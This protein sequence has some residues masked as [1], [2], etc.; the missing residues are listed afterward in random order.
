VPSFRP[1]LSTKALFVTLVSSVA[2]ICLSTGAQAAQ[3]KKKHA[4]AAAPAPAP[5]PKGPPRLIVAIS[6]DQ[7]SADLF[8]QYRKLYTGGLA[9]LQGGAVFASGF[10]SHAA[11]ETCPGHSTILTGVHPGRNGII[12]NNWYDL[13]LKRADKRVYCAE[14]EKDKDSTSVAPVVSAVHLK[15]PTLGELMKL[16][17]PESRNVAVSAKDR[18]VV[19]M[20]GHKIDEA[21]WYTTQGFSSFN[22]VTL[23]APVLAANARLL[24]L[25]TKGAPALVAPAWCEPMARPIKAGAVTVGT[26]RFAVDVNNYDFTPP[27]QIKYSPRVDAATLD[28]AAGL[29]DS[30]KL[31]RGAAPDILSV[32]LSATDYIGHAYGTQGVEMCIQ[33]HELDEKLGAFFAKLD[34]AGIDYAVVLTA[35]HGGIDL[36]E[37]LREQGVPEAGRADGGLYGERIGAKIAEEL[38]LEPGKDG[39]VYSEGLFGDYWISPALSP[40]L[41]AKVAEKLIARLRADSQVSEVFTREQI[42]ATPYPQGHPQDWTMLQRARAS[43]D[44]ARSGDVYSVLR[45]TIVPV[46]TPAANANTVTTHGSPWDYDRRVPMLFWRKGVAGMEQPQPV[47]TV[48][49]A[50]TL[51]AMIGLKVAEGQF[52]GRC[53]DVDGGPKDSCGK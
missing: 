20:G 31:G 43:F 19:M 15:V 47:E 38:G 33:Q 7:F 16:Q 2:A 50:P 12:A 14:D 36:P 8:A 32:S 48:D 4:V 1:A 18:A 44:P 39:L 9:R 25:V 40:E 30:M 3:P 23:A 45:R 52:D 13:S 41:R 51:A 42:A 29:V 24:A 6:V 22:G 10:Q 26:G 21:Y 53:L 46:T 35:D 27:N 49:I 37:R 28:I 34:A 11:T 5:A 17:W